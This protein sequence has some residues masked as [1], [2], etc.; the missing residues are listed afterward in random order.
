MKKLQ[1]LKNNLLSRR[2]IS[3]LGP[4]LYASYLTKFLTHSPKII[5]SGN[6]NSLDK[7]IGMTAKYF[8]YRGHDFIFDCRFCDEQLDENSCSFS[9]AREIYIRDCYFK[10]HKPSVY[11][12]ARTVID[13]GANRGVFSALMTTRADFIVS[14]EC[15]EQYT[16]I[17]RHNMAKNNYSTYA[18]E[19]VFI[20]TGGSTKSASDTISIDELFIRHNIKFVDL[21]KIDIEGSEFSIFES[22][23]W[24][25][26]VG[27]ISMEVH[28][29]HGDPSTIL[30]T[31][32]KQGFCFIIADENLQRITDPKQANFIYAWR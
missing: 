5:R 21:I 23:N 17:I 28:P 3:V 8:H 32:D 18:L 16:P 13:L 9:I 25:Q 14:V 30:R 19:T 31:I 20:G 11:D 15:E 12:T 26:H 1:K 6:L 24:L 7:S 4:S 2:A 22:P 27:A 29:Q 10:W